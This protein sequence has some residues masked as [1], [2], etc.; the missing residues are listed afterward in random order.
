[1]Q[2]KLKNYGHMNEL[3]V[4]NKTKLRKPWECLQNMGFTF[5]WI[6]IISRW[7]LKTHN[8][9]ASLWYNVMSRKESLE[10]GNN[11]NSLKLNIDI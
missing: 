3:S 2:N 7:D 10:I 8:N 6:S 9:K 4:P 11:G 5:K 1:M